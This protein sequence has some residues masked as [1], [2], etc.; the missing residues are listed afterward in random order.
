VT[1]STTSPSSSAAT[2]I[3]RAEVEALQLALRDDLP[4]NC[5]EAL[6]WV[7]L[8]AAGLG[9]GF[10]DAVTAAGGPIPVVQRRAFAAF[11]TPRTRTRVLNPEQMAERLGQL[12]PWIDAGIGVVAV[13]ADVVRFADHPACAFFSAG[14]A[15]PPSSRPVVAVV[16]S[17]N[18]GERYLQ[19]TAS[20]SSSLAR[21]GAVIV[22]GG[23]IG[24]DTAAQ[25]AARSV[26]GDVV[27]ITGRHL[28]GR[29]A[30]PDE[31]KLDAGL[32][33]LTPYGPWSPPGASRSRFAAR[34]A[35]IAAM[36]DVV[37]A[38]CGG[39]QS[40]TRHTIEAALRFGRPV[41]A[42]RPH[43]DA[44]DA[45]LAAMADRLVATKTGTLID[46]DVDLNDLLSLRRGVVPGAVSDWAHGP[47]Q[48]ALPMER[49]PPPM[50]SAQAVAANDD[51]APLVRL[52]CLR[53]ALTI[54]DAAA[55][56]STT[57][58]E[59]LVDVAL[60]EMD[61]ALRREGALLTL[62]SAACKA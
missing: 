18:A 36:A 34:N 46:D 55:A 3:T 51:A 59:L 41:V 5:S 22:S 39:E 14:R 13:E 7:A 52:L 27:M 62:P 12:L 15:L 9:G 26:N 33:W 20:L 30:I 19:R 8:D 50:L 45:D 32:C 2:P 11:T 35:F 47:E 24:V 17:R 38:V 4:V 42:V 6:A 60:L 58:R 56:L 29:A 21:Q 25:E 48:P 44:G 57:V 49:S 16:G 31:V 43:R 10:R 1:T 53:G 61:G 54:D 40:G 23:A 28:T 37:I